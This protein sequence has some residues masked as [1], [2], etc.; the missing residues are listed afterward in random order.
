[1]SEILQGTLGEFVTQISGGGTPARDIAEYWTGKIPW[2]SVKDLTSS[3]PESTAER[4]SEHGLSSSASRLIPSGIP[5]VAT[6]MAVGRT[7]VYSSDVA[8]NQDLK[9]IFP[10]GELLHRKYLFHFLKANEE[11]LASKG[12]G[13]TVKGIRLED[14]EQLPICVPPLPEQ[15][16]IAEILSGIDNARAGLVTLRKKHRA[17]LTSLRQIIF[18]ESDVRHCTFEEIIEQRVL[19]TTRRGTGEGSNIPLVKMGDIARGEIKLGA[20]ERIE[21][22][23]DIK[24]LLLKKG[25]ILFNTRNTPSLVG[26]TAIFDASMQCCYDNNLM[27]IRLVPWVSPWFLNHLMNSP[28][29]LQI[30]SSVSSGTT[31]VAAIYWNDLKRIRIPL[32]SLPRQ[33][34][35]SDSFDA[36]IEVISGVTNKLNGLENIKSATSSE[37]LSGRKRVNI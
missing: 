8:I 15:K 29:F 14:L 17:L 18:D 11:T 25:D 20:N 19:G 32:P 2:I 26:K 16:K 4:I 28:R 31:S 9:A 23:D 24:D 3:N 1:M 27:R 22:A 10:N 35:L 6:R 5:I 12:T 7:A 30:L 33:Q 36:V 21:Y 13:S 37:L 34:Q